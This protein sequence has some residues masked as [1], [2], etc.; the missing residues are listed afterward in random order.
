MLL[1]WLIKHGWSHKDPNFE[2]KHKIFT[3]EVMLNEFN[4]GNI[5]QTNTTLDTNK[6]KYIVSKWK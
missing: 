5:R 2:K 4:N 1:A 3:R 6:L